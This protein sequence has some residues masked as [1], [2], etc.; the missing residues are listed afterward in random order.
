M[1]DWR[2]GAAFAVMVLAGCTVSPQQNDPLAGGAFTEVVEQTPVKPEKAKG[3][4]TV[5][6]EKGPARVQLVPYRTG[7]SSATVESLARRTGCV[8]DGGAGLLTEAGPVEVY[9]VQ[10]EDGRKFMAQCELRQCRPMQR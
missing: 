1:F 2:F 3:G 9:R 8:P 5:H 6:D 7:V 4:M 10:C